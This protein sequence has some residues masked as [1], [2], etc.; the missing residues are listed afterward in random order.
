MS[1]SIDV[2]VHCPDNVDSHLHLVDRPSMDATGLTMCVHSLLFLLFTTRFTPI[3][4]GSVICGKIISIANIGLA[5]HQL[6]L[7]ILCTVG[8]FLIYQL[9]ISQLIYF[10]II[11]KNPY[12]YYYKFS[13]AI[14]TA[15]ATASK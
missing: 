9:I 10:I 1:A 7:F 14:I 8:G 3:G 12:E 5:L 4:V 15:F 11:R 6:S 13:S 2:L